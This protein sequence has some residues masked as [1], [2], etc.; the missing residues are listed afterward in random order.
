M[1]YKYFHNPNNILEIINHYFK[2]ICCENNKYIHNIRLKKW[3][4]RN[5]IQCFKNNFNGVT[6]KIEKLYNQYC[7]YKRLNQEKDTIMSKIYFT[8]YYDQI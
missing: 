1:H 4:K 7:K 3:D 8:S 5:D 2:D 6:N